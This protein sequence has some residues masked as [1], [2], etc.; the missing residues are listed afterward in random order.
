MTENMNWYPEGGMILIILPG[1]DIG[2]MLNLSQIFSIVV[3]ISIYSLINGIF[4][5][6]SFSV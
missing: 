1:A 4:H 3:R 6:W 5:E 2:K